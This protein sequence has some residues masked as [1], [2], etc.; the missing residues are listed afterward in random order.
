VKLAAVAGWA[1]PISFASLDEETF[2]AANDQE[3]IDALIERLEQMCPELVVLEATSRYD[4]HLI[5]AAIAA[6]SIRV[7]VISSRQARD[8]AKATGCLAKTYRID[9][10]ILAASGL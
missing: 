6:R 8:F 9:A 1:Y 7:A 5:A 2:G 10:E 3:G 4:E